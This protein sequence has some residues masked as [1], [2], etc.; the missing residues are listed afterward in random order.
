MS[1][2]MATTASSPQPNDQTLWEYGELEIKK[3]QVEEKLTQLRETT[4]TTQDGRHV[5]LSANSTTAGRESPS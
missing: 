1:S 3:T 4:S 5:V 2:W